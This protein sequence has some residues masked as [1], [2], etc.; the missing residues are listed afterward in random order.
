[1]GGSL[2]FN[3]PSREAIVKKIMK[4]QNLD[5]DFQEFLKIDRSNDGSSK[6]NIS[7]MENK[8]TIKIKCGIA[9]L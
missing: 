4:L 6:R 1:M 2:S 8:S 3:A 7:N 5:Y 9:N